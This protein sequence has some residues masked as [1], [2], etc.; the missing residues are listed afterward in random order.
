M[1]SYFGEPQ[2]NKD[3]KNREVAAF[4]DKM[5]YNEASSDYSSWGLFY[6][7]LY[8]LKIDFIQSI[9]SVKMGSKYEV[10]D[11]FQN[12]MCDCD[13]LVT[14][15]TGICPRVDILAIDERLITLESKLDEYVKRM[16]FSNKTLPKELIKELKEIYRYINFLMQ[17]HN[18]GLPVSQASNWDISASIIGE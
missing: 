18:L 13:D 5:N 8:R 17:R 16:K 7:Q 3:F 14:M 2:V 10:I 1:A 11:Y 6:S 4:G 12:C 15:I 9:R